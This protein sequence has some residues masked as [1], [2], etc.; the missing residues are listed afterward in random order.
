MRSGRDRDEAA[1]VAEW[2]RLRRAVVFIGCV[3]ILAI[4]AAIGLYH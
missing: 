2:R 4:A 3:A 1:L